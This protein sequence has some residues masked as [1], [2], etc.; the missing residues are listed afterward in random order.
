[1]LFNDREE[2]GRQLS[3]RLLHYKQA[4]ETLVL[5]LARGGV[6]TAHAIAQ[7]LQLPLDVMVVRK[8]GAPDNEELALGAVTGSGGMV[9]NDHLI[10]LLGVS[11]DY[12]KREIEREKKLA[13]KRY[14]LYRGSMESLSIKNKR[15]ILVDDGIATGA[16]ILVAIQAIRAELPE[17]I[18]LAVPVAAPE[19]LKKISKEVEETVCLSHPAFFEAVGSFYRIFEPVTDETIVS[20]LGSIKNRS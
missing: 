1:M 12:M 14:L 18:I 4:K 16:S 11:N 3:L 15:V 17:K 10:T 7:A 5:G 9:L 8:I 13:Q 2:A 20:I 19:S 6:I